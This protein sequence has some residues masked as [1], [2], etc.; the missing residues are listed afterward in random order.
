MKRA[1]FIPLFLILLIVTIVGGAFVW[2]HA[3]LFAFIRWPWTSGDSGRAYLYYALKQ[4]DGFV[5]ARAPKGADGQPL[6]QPQTLQHFGDGFGLLPSDSISSIQ[7]SPDG[8]YL[9]ID[10]LHGDSEQVWMYDIRNMSMSFLPAS[11]SGNFL[12]WISGGN[13]HAFLYRPMLPLGPDVPMDADIWNPG[14]W[15]VDAQTG[16]HKNIDISES[17]ADIIDAAS[18]PDGTHIVYSTTTGLG[19]GS[20]T[21]VMNKDGSNRAQLLNLKDTQQSIAG[22]FTWSPDGAR[23]AYERLA[24][25]ATPFLAAGLWVMD[26]QGGQQQHVADTDGGHGFMPVWSPDSKKLAFVTRTNGNDTHA[27]DN[28]QALHSAIAMVDLATLYVQQV[29]SEEQTHL[30]ININPVWASYGTQITFTALNPVNRDL[31]GTQ[32]YW[33]ATI[34]PTSNPNDRKQARIVPLSPDI[35]HVIAAG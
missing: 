20:T 6:A 4:P 34:T 28:E 15:V 26:T 29:G 8:N 7:L 35:A 25:S 22:L 21:F 1:P 18:S 10:G 23:I 30:P 19:M 33:S 17:S 27:D 31:G 11:V 13:G 24:D 3:A 14:L 32:H 9:A 16:S 5:L 12:H 2:Q